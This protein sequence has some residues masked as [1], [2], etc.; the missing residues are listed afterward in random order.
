MC[1]CMCLPVCARLEWYT[2]CAMPA[3]VMLF[4]YLDST[5]IRCVRGVDGNG[6]GCPR[7][8]VCCRLLS[9]QTCY[10]LQADS[11]ITRASPSLRG[12]DFVL[13]AEC[14]LQNIQFCSP[15]SP[16]T[17]NTHIQTFRFSAQRKEYFF[18]EIYSYV[19]LD[20]MKAIYLIKIKPYASV[21]MC[22]CV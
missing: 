3:A 1:V 14:R 2:L 12:G 22:V 17:T 4:K 16:S 7:Q 9:A 19:S 10:L 15:L 8:G 20:S 11:S 13:K 6:N 18:N 21:C 5:R